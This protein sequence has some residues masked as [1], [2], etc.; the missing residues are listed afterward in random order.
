MDMRGHVGPFVESAWR[1]E[2]PRR[3]LPGAPAKCNNIAMPLDVNE[4]RSFYASPLGDV[5]RRLIGR[6]LRARWDNCAGLSLMGL[7]F[8]APYLD[9]FRE[10]AM[11]ALAF[12]PA[13]QGVVNWPASGRSSSALVESVMLPLPDASIDRILVVHA[14]ETGEHPNALLEEVWRVLT[15]GGRAIFVIPSRR[16]VW[17]RVDGTPFGFGRP[18]SKGQLR[19]LMRETLFSPVYWGEALYAPPF[20][21]GVF[22]NWATAFER[23]GAALG[24]PFAGVYIVEATKQLYRPIGV[25]RVIRREAPA[26]HPALAPSAHRGVEG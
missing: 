16:G 3:G 22:L 26:L 10:E 15:P 24:L 20:Q 14:L 23:I 21:R 18:Y 1:R 6:V 19:E 11:R 4:L 12:M 2:T 13:E 17:A 5:A 25:R 7:G 9:R 8:A